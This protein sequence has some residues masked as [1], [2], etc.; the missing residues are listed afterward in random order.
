VIIELKQ[1]DDNKDATSILPTI[2]VTTGYSVTLTPQGKTE[3]N[4]PFRHSIYPV[5][6]TS[7]FRESYSHTHTVAAVQFP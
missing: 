6:F 3:N 4:I 5:L 7:T 1:T 2:F